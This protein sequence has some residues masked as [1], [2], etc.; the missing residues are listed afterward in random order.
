MPLM[1]E[2]SRDRREERRWPIS[3]TISRTSSVNTCRAPR[4]RSRRRF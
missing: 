2:V 1:I 3:S 4:R